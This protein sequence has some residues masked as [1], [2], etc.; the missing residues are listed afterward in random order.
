MSQS[1]SI[2]IRE[3][4]VFIERN[5][6]SSVNGGSAK[7]AILCGQRAEGKLVGTGPK[8]SA[9]TVV[10]PTTIVTVC[11]H[12][13]LSG[14][15]YSYLPLVKAWPIEVCTKNHTWSSALGSS[16]GHR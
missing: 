4:L 1:S 6:W 3:N 15:T 8:I 9:I 5:T 7:Q 11:F 16:T 13:S 14:M 10:A 2:P 12:S